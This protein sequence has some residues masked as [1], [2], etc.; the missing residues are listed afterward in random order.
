MRILQK[1]N[2]L[3][4]KCVRLL[5][6]IYKQHSLIKFLRSICLILFLK[7]CSGSDLLMS[8]LRFDQ[9]TGPKCL[10]I[11]TKIHSVE[12]QYIK[13]S[14]ISLE[15]NQKSSVKIVLFN[16][17]FVAVT[18]WTGGGM[19]ASW[20][21]RSSLDQTVWFRALARDTVLWSWERHLTLTV[22]LSNQV[23]IGCWWI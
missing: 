2:S 16:Y 12:S 8:L 22:P 20:L 17:K 15:H 23:H 18:K 14:I 7:A 21:V 19:E 3:N 4:N 9:R 6:S 11:F 1:I 10:V 13:A 5:H